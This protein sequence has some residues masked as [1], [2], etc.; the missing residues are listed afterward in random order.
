M[1]ESHLPGM[2]PLSFAQPPR[3]IA[4]LVMV[5]RP[6]T[7]IFAFT[8]RNIDDVI[9]SPI[10]RRQIIGYYKLYRTIQRESEIRDLERQWNPL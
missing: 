6:L 5:Q 10:A 1:S 4:P 8:G 9:N 7:R 3:V 2:N